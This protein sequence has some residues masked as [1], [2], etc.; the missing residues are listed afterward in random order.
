MRQIFMKLFFLMFLIAGVGYSATVFKEAGKPSLEEAASSI[1]DLSALY[2]KKYLKW[3]KTVRQLREFAE[4]EHYKFNFQ[5]YHDVSFFPISSKKLRVEYSYA[6][7]NID[8]HVSEK[9]DLNKESE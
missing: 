4:A 9:I 6:V 2:K 3:P 8:M 5:N 7:E 1:C